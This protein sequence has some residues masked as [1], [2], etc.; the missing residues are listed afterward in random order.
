MLGHNDSV[1]APAP[2]RP[3]PRW[4][5]ALLAVDAALMTSATVASAVLRDIA[6]VGLTADQRTALTI[7][8]YEERDQYYQ[9][10][11]FFRYG[12]FGW[13]REAMRH[14]LFPAEGRILLGAAGGRRELVAIEAAGYQVTAFDP[15]ANFHASLEKLSTTAIVLRG[16]YEDLVDAVERCTG[17]LLPLLDHRYDAVIF[18]WGSLSNVLDIEMVVRVFAATRRIAPSAAVLASVLPPHADEL[19]RRSKAIESARRRLHR[20]SGTYGV[21][22]RPSAG[23]NREYTAAEFAEIAERGGYRVV[24][25][26]W[27]EFPHALMVPHVG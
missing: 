12:L 23:F 9:G 18:G 1:P 13:E 15:G 4:V 22:Y 14:T 8:S 3:A 11:D 24:A 16:S 7:R 19:S 5:D 20:R 17:P 10:S 6:C 26:G 25:S 2:N 21:R 27:S